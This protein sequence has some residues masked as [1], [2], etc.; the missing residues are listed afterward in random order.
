MSAVVAV[1]GQV[2]RVTRSRA[3]V[4]PAARWG[5]ALVLL[6]TLAGVAAPLLTPYSP[7]T[8]GPEALL[9]PVPQHPLGTDEF[10]RD[11]L[12]RILYGIRLDLLVAATAVPLGGLAGV[13][14]GVLC[15]LHPA[16]DVV[17]QRVF[18]VML[19]FTALIL[20]VTLAAILGPGTAAVFWTVAGINVPL[21]GRIAR[22]AVRS[23]QDREYV[24]AA[25]ALGAGRPRILFGE[26]LP[27]IL[28]ALVV[29]AALSLSTAVFVEGAMSFVGIGVS[30]PTP[31]LG[32]LLRTGATFLDDSPAYALGPVAVVV[33]LVIGFNLLA[34]GLNKGLL[35]R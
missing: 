7:L 5:L 2:R 1:R 9:G 35:K 29:Q 14:L 16:L 6:L 15:G 31:S 11:L 27:N 4:A 19:A 21:F 13:V 3:L 10:G 23:E 30:P 33:G 28:D 24:L 32:A 18:D 20:G 26:I 22:D 17:L 25:V 8:Q 12:S 34:D